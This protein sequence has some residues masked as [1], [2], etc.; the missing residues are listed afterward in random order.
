V[1]ER[2]VAGW[3]GECMSGEW[4]MSK[5][6]DALDTPIGETSR[7]SRVVYAEGQK[8]GPTG[9]EEEKEGKSAASIPVRQREHYILKDIARGAKR[10]KN[11]NRK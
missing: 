8:E 3:K 1:Y 11:K 4:G 2:V 10:A 5:R 6:E 7:I 9:K